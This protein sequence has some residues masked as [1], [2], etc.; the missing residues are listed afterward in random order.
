MAMA[1]SRC[2]VSGLPH[3]RT[4]QVGRTIAVLGWA[5]RNALISLEVAGKGLRR[6]PQI[7][8]LPRSLSITNIGEPPGRWCFAPRASEAPML[9]YF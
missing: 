1:A 8:R 6:L 7:G 2:R 5:L 9:D 3:S 4:M